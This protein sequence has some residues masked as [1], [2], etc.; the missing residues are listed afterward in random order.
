MFL[1]QILREPRFE[2]RDEIGLCGCANG[3]QEDRLEDDLVLVYRLKS[4]LSIVTGCS[5][6]EICNIVGYVKSMCRK[7]RVVG[8][9][10]GFHLPDVDNRPDRTI[11]FIKKARVG[12]MY[13]YHYVP[14]KAETRMM[15]RLLVGEVG[16]GTEIC[17]E[18]TTA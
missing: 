7:P 3:W 9:L 4:G 15:K 1:G 18:E 5:H 17:L 13:P 16:V 2:D 10:D 6:S 11:E 12:T 14:L 8:I